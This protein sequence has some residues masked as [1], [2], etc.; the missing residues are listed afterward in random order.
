MA[1]GKRLLMDAALRLSARTDATQA[2]SLREVAREAQLNHNTFYR[3]FD[4]M[5]ELLRGVVDEFCAAL[6]SGINEARARA[7]DPNRFTEVVMDWLLDFAVAN[8]EAFAVSFRVLHGPPSQARDDARATVQQLEGDLLNALLTSPTL[9]PLLAPSGSDALRLLV[10]VI[11]A[12]SFAMCVRHIEQPERGGEHKAEHKAECI[13]EAKLLFETLVLG[14][15]A[16][17]QRQ[18]G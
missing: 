6:R 5:E 16:R 14:T 2:L 3:H 10:Q 15:L 9:G 8:P 12:Q 13:A 11:V 1:H 7:G 4:S 18:S 17:Q